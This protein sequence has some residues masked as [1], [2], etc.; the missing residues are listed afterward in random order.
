MYEC[1][2]E[3][4][5]L[6]ASEV[7]CTGKNENPLNPP[8][9]Q[10]ENIYTIPGTDDNATAFEDEVQI[11]LSASDEKLFNIDLDQFIEQYLPT[12]ARTVNLNNEWIITDTIGNPDFPQLLQD[13][14]N[15]DLLTLT[16]KNYHFNLISF[17]SSYNRSYTSLTPIWHKFR[18]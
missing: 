5:E 17:L 13:N 11:H 2:T 1:T 16:Q 3:K 4:P 14:P 9:L 12:E 6:D 18:N 15:F 10:P 7:K 8:D